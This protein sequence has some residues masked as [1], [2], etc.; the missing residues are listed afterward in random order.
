MKSNND[1]KTLASIILKP[2]R[3]TSLLRKHPWVY[4]GALFEV[5]GNPRVGETVRVHAADGRLLGLGAWSPRSQLRVRMWTFDEMTTVDAD[6]FRERLAVAAALRSSRIDESTTDAYR[7]VY[8]ESDAIPGLIVD[9]YGQWLLCQFLSAGVEFWRDAIIT[10]LRDMFPGF[11]LLERSDDV[12][13]VREGLDPRSGDLGDGFPQA[14]LRV[15][16]HG[17]PLLV[18]VLHGHKT[19]FYLDQRDNRELLRAICRGRDVLDCFAYTGAFAVAALNGGATSVVDC[20]SSESALE[21]ARKNVGLQRAIE[22]SYVQH[23]GD[24]FHVL[25]SFRDARRDF[26]IIVLDPPKFASTAAQTA[27]AARGYKDINL[28]AFK[29]LRPGGLL[30]TFSCSGH[31]TPPLFRKIVADAALDAQVDAVVLGE[32]TQSSD[33]A[34][35]LNIPEALYLKGLYCQVK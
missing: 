17:M 2:G 11:R 7:L 1:A 34:P 28:L 31:I 33:H 24:V 25:R 10:H 23:H 19:G 13:R 32:M 27:R 12:M 9:R 26:D 14:E 35:G 6:M 3:E 30:L 5:Q 21:L 16:E 18:D 20:E 22:G 29:L 4:S 15:L 8:S